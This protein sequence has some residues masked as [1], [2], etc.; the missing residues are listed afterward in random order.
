MWLSIPEE[1][2]KCDIPRGTYGMQAVAGSHVLNG[3]PV[4]YLKDTE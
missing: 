4:S 1:E 3:C 2:E